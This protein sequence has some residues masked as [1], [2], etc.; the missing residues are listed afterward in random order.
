MM[1][2]R[3]FNLRGKN[4]DKACMTPQSCRAPSEPYLA[5]GDISR[6]TERSSYCL[7]LV[8]SSPKS[9]EQ[10]TVTGRTDWQEYQI[11]LAE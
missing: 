6:I 9:T 11:A 7:P 4:C 8:M 1:A 5:V 2:E 3:E 10:N